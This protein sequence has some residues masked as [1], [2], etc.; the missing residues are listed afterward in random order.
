MSLTIVSRKPASHVLIGGECKRGFVLLAVAK[1]PAETE[2][3]EPLTPHRAAYL[4]AY[5]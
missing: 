1:G 3:R 4:L 5:P 2:G